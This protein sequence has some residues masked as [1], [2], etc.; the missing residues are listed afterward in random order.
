MIPAKPSSK[1]SVACVGDLVSGILIGCSRRP[2]RMVVGLAPKG[3]GLGDVEDAEIPSVKVCGACNRHLDGLVVAMQV[4]APETHRTVPMVFTLPELLEVWD[5]F[6]ADLQ[7][8]LGGGDV[9][10]AD[11]QFR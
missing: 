1:D 2:V 9:W 4:S 7:A 8:K 3:F 11:G 6:F 10:E 5:D